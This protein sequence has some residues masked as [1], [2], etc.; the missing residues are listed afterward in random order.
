MFLLTAITTLFTLLIAYAFSKNTRVITLITGNSRKLADLEAVFESK[1]HGANSEVVEIQGT[2][3]E[4]AIKKAETL[5]AKIGPCLCEDTSLGLPCTE[6]GSKQKEPI[7]PALIKHL[8]DACK[9]GDGNLVDALKAISPEHLT[10]EY[11]SSVSI[12]TGST[13]TVI[14]CVTKC[15]LQHGGGG[16]GE[17]DPYVVPV[18]YTLT[19]HENGKTIVLIN[20]HVVENPD[21]KTI[22]EMPERRAEV[23]PRYFALEAAKAWLFSNG[24]TIKK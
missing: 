22:G 3:L 9:V 12:C 5:Y 21:E 24:Y 23:H 11:T 20:D 2:P 15:I 17:I 18:C 8:I 16:K 1:L 19:R 6:Y 7:F 14:Q 10:Y 4:I 13:T